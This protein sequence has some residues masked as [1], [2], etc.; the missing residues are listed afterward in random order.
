VKILSGRFPYISSGVARFRWLPPAGILLLATLA[1]VNSFPG[2]F[3]L[4]DLQIVR[5]NPLV[6]AP[7]LWP[8]LTSDY[9]G[10]DMNSGLYRPLTILSFAVNR[11]LLGAD[12]WGFHLVNVLLHAMVAL[13]VFLLVACWHNDRFV[14][15]LAA[16][17]FAVH[18]I[19]TEVINEA[20]GRGEL[21]AA[22]FGL[23]ALW[24]ARRP[25]HG[26]AV[27]SLLS[28][29]AALLS[30]E[31]AVVLLVLLPA[32]DWFFSPSGFPVRRWP[33]YLALAAVGGGWWLARSWLAVRVAEPLPKDP[34]FI[35]LAFAD[36][37]SRITTALK[38]QWQLLGKQLLPLDLQAV[39][40]TATPEAMLLG[41]GT[42]L[43]LVV[44][45]ASLILTAVVARGLYRRQPIALYGAFY[46]LSILP[47]SNLFFAAGVT[48]AERLAYFPSVWCCGAAAML[49][50]G[51]TRN[52]KRF[53]LP[54]IA[55]LLVI[56][57]MMG[58]WRRNADFADPV[59]LWSTNVQTAPDNILAWLYLGGSL[60]ESG[61]IPEAE[62]TYRRMLELAPGFPEGLRNYAQFLLQE[63]RPAEAEPLAEKATQ[64]GQGTSPLAYLLLAEA[65]YKLG[66]V[67]PARRS[68][69]A[70]DHY[71][72]HYWYY[73]ALRGMV[74]EALA[75]RDEALAC[76]FK[77][78]P[79]PKKSDLARRA[80]LLL[81]GMGRPAEAEPFLREAVAETGEALAWNGLG[82][83]LAL[84]GKTPEARQASETAVRLDPDSR[85]YRENLQRLR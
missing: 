23:L 4:D 58:T 25:G 71:Y 74:L 67:E 44:L 47:A 75:Q 49:M 61:R 60:Y 27:W 64:T 55:G 15:W 79:W 73:W 84:Q 76:Y 41:P 56:V 80:G 77:A 17:L 8:I 68:L 2:V 19:H 42:P 65:Q 69:D 18:P 6:A 62:S 38:L 59:R 22:G 85:Q 26:P 10:W 9:W 34:F 82:V 50:V 46:L 20:V 39:Y 57:L 70:V 21:L 37:W 54:W 1:Y 40:S 52:W 72:Q 24:L 43:G 33:Y 45:I 14:A 29:A 5:D 11:L 32:A 78:R 12:A 13:L 3:L 16:A 36:T 83:A 48:F 35:P 30:K 53:P 66:K 28:V 7:R 63:G 51:A 81:L 31:H